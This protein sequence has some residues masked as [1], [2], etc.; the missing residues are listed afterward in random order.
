MDEKKKK[1]ENGLFVVCIFFCLFVV[2]Y[3]SIKPY[4]E[5]RVK[6]DYDRHEFHPCHVDHHTT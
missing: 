3:S 5:L 1:E 4:Y 2:F 6:D